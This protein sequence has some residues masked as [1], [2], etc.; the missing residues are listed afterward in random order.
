MVSEADVRLVL[1]GIDDPEL[2]CSIVQ[3]GLVESVHIDEDRVGI[4]LL[5]TFTG[6]PALD[7][8]EGDVRAQVSAMDGVATCTVRWRYQPAWSPDRISEAGRNRLHKHGV[9][10]PTACCGE[11]AEAVSLTTSAVPCPYC[12]STRTILDSPFG[13]TRCR[14]IH[15]CEACRNQFEH[16]KPTN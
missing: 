8:I 14:Q 2:P 7:M 11:G 4:E 1:D 15:L 13:P 6:C 9:T 12:G 16:M 10:T 3:L 5:P